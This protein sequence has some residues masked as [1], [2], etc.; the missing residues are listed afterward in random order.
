MNK[1]YDNGAV[2]LGNVTMVIEE[3]E[4]EIKENIDMIFCDMEE[5]LKDM[6]ELQQIDKD[7]IVSIHYENPMGYD[8]T[9]WDTNDIVK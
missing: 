7:M 3:I 4:R 6:K 2:M 1:I 5:L 9:C 8:Y